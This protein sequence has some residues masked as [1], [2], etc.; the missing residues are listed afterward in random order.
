M[1]LFLGGD[2]IF[3]DFVVLLLDGFDL[4]F[5]VVVIS[6]NLYVLFIHLDCYLNCLRLLVLL[7]CLLLHLGSRFFGLFD[8]F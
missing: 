7:F 2:E 5:E 6:L 8:I 4:F 3:G 1:G